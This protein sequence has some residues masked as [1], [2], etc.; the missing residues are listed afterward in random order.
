MLVKLKYRYLKKKG[1]RLIKSNL[2]K[3]NYF[4]FKLILKKLYNLNCR[5]LLVEGGN[6]LSKNI[7]KNKLFNQFYM[8]KSQKNLSKSVSYKDFNCFNYLLQNYKNRTKIKTKLG[9]D[10]ITLYKR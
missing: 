1:I 9:K 2:I 7:L 6:D 4:D 8:F 5:N 10:T 3:N